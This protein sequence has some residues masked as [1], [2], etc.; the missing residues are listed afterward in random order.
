VDGARDIGT[1]PHAAALRSPPHT[2]ARSLSV[3]DLFYLAIAALGF[4]ILWA[5]TKACDRV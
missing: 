3:L 4:L 2:A 1:R 5:V